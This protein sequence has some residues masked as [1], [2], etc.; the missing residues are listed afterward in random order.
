MER[1]LPDVAHFH[2]WSPGQKS[3]ENPMMGY[4]ALADVLVVTGESESMLAEA[5]AAG[6]SVQIYPL[7]SRKDGIF[8]RVAVAAIDWIVALAEREPRNNRGTTRPQQGLELLCSRL[9]AGGYVRPHRD[10]AGVQRTMVER[11]LARMFDGNLGDFVRKGHSE[12]EDVA[13]RVRAMLGVP[14]PDSKP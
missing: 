12:I 1:A 8:T 14:S 5:S 4:L 2:R 3:S 10:L 13:D 7:P 6:K 9:V 11:G